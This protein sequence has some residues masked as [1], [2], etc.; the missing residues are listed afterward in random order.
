MVVMPRKEGLQLLGKAW[1]S[2]IVP[3]PSLTYCKALESPPLPIPTTERRSVPVG[4]VFGLCSV[5]PRA[6]RRIETCNRPAPSPG[7]VSSAGGNRCVDA[8]EA[9]TANTLCQR[10]RSE[11]V[12]QC[13][14]RAAQRTC[15]RARCRRALR[16]FFARG[17]P[18]LTYALL[19]CP[20]GGSACAERRR[21]TFVPSCA[22]SGPGPAPPS[23][24]E[25]LE[26]CERSRVCRP[27]L[28]AF[29]ASCAP[30]PSAPDGCL[31]DQRA[32]C[33]RAYAGLV[34][35]AVTPNY[36]DN[37]SARV[38]PWCHCGASGNRREDCEAFRGLFTRNPCLDGAIQAFASGWP[39][40]LL[41]QLNPQGH[42]EH[43][44]LQ[45]SRTAQ[46]ATPPCLPGPPLWPA[47]PLKR[48]WL[49]SHTSPGALTPLPF[50]GLDIL[51]AIP[52]SEGYLETIGVSQKVNQERVTFVAE[53]LLEPQIT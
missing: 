31:W 11:Y 13:L 10:L 52:W 24:L 17:P 12:A 23:C 5:S 29:Q 44:L 20:C 39:P 47:G 15:P 48:D 43:S 16:R 37:A 36:V 25:P 50:I 34:G 35:T 7:S 4:P 9:C 26:V 27:R 45:R 53:A 8:A 38:A 18:A 33:V 6:G 1:L 40:V 2:P 30:A 41:D 32:H 49:T 14:G 22:F 46:P 42:P 21:Q 19:F 3:S 51:C 28:L